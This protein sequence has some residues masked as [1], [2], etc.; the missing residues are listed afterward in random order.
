MFGELCSGSD[1]GR[2]GDETLD[3]RDGGWRRSKGELGNGGRPR[4]R[5]G[6]GGISV[7]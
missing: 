7:V 5:S 6:V 4:A 3:D 1:Y 2:A